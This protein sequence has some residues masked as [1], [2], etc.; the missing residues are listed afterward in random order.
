MY[1]L[2]KGGTMS[3]EGTL[4]DKIWEGGHAEGGGGFLKINPYRPG[5]FAKS[6]IRSRPISFYGTVHKVSCSVCTVLLRGAISC[7][8]VLRWAYMY[9]RTYIER[10]SWFRLAD[11]LPKLENSGTPRTETII[12]RRSLMKYVRWL[13]KTGCRPAARERNTFVYFL[14][15]FLRVCPRILD[16]SKARGALWNIYKFLGPDFSESRDKQR[17][18]SSLWIFPRSFPRG[19]TFRRD[20]SLRAFRD[21]RWDS[22]WISIKHSVKNGEDGIDYKLKQSFLSLSPSLFICFVPLGLALNSISWCDCDPHTR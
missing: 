15:G 9:T 3:S 1:L 19:P 16:T 10:S 17:I 8:G 4:K 22:A 21:N 12:S 6:T 5:L 20:K 13:G 11:R 14:H 2:G 18:H 7:L